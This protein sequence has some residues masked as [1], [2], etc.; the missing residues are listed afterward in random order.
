M[1]DYDRR[2]EA[3][4]DKPVTADKSLAAAYQELMEFNHSLVGP[5]L[6]PDLVRAQQMTVKAL[7]LLEEVRKETYD[8]RMLVRRIGKN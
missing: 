1:Y 4:L 8:L 6:S 7:N 3:K 2:S 5:E